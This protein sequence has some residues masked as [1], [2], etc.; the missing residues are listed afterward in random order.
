MDQRVFIAIGSNLGDRIENCCR[1]IELITADKEK[2]SLIRSSSFYETE[3]WG[4]VT[5]GAFINS[6]IEVR[7][8]LSPGSLLEFLKS[9]EIEMGRAPSPP[10][11]RWGPRLIDLDIIFYGDKILEE[12]GLVIPHPYAHLRAFVLVPLGEIAPGFVHPLL[13]K[14]VSE[15][16]ESLP[17]KKGVRRLKGQ[18]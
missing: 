11:V 12:E 7:T 6:V 18:T 2:V 16:I 4:M 13:R 10:S 3:P 17:D 5:Q 9:I 1:A 14:K 8:A 15:L